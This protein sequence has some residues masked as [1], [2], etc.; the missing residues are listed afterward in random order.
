MDTG[1]QAVDLL[2]Q[3]RTMMVTL[4]TGTGDG[5][6]NARRMPRTDTGHLAQTLV[7]LAR[8]LLG[9]PTAGHTLET[10]TLSNGNAVDHLVL[11]EHLR[12]RNRLL[13]MLLHPVNL[14]GDGTTVQLD[15]DD[16]SLLLTL[17]DQT[18]L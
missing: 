10:L 2:V 9:V 15:L 11:R 16:V 18:N 13:E 14:V 1:T 12:H 7:R 6:G 3:L 5:E 17:L 4:L 8:Q